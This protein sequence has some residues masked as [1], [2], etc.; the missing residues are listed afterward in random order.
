MKLDNKEHIRTKNKMQGVVIH[1]K[2]PASMLQEA[3][4][5]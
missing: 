1:R 4:N 3:L 5:T 2:F